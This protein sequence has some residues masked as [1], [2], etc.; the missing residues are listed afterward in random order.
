MHGLFVV[1]VAERS[2]QGMLQYGVGRISDSHHH[3]WFL[4]MGFYRLP[5]VDLITSE[6]KSILEYYNCRS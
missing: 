6:Y 4:D 3:G 2:Q 1:D 5:V